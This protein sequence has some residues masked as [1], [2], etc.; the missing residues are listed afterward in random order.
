MLAFPAPPFPLL[1][2]TLIRLPS[3]LTAKPPSFLRG[4]GKEWNSED[5]DLFN[6]GLHF[7]AGVFFFLFLFLRILPVYRTNLLFLIP[8]ERNS[9]V[10]IFFLP[11]ITSS[12][13][14][15][16]QLYLIAGKGCRV[17]DKALFYKYK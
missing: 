15:L 8:M 6:E 2:T 4:L 13:Y 12:S 10:Y 9:N 1:Q 11:P 5:K 16:V 7:V 14:L 17:L 3:E